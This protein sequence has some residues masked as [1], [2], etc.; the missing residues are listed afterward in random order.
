[1]QPIY[2]SDGEVVAIV[3][4]GH[5]H[6]IDGEWIGFLRGAEVFGFNGEYIGYLSEDRR[7]LRSRRPPKRELIPPPTLPTRLRGIPERFP[8][9]TLF[10]QLPY[11]TIDVFEEYPEQF[12]YVSDLRPDIV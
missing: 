12:R 1:M 3:H 7:L 6:N 9:A 8:L 11:S 4:Q 2:R 10:K 5:L